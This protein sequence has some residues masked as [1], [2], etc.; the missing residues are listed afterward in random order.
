MQIND[1]LKMNGLDQANMRRNRKD[2]GRS[3]DSFFVQCM[4][5]NVSYP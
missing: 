3:I 4:M 1:A 2:E 5:L